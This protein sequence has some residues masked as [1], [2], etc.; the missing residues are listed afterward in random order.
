MLK[1][2]VLVLQEQ[3]LRVE[4]CFSSTLVAFGS[5]EDT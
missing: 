2:L 4:S 3:K 1:V 5:C